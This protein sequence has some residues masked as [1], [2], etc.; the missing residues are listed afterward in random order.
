MKKFILMVLLLLSGCTC[1]PNK[2]YP[3]HIEEDIGITL[4]NAYAVNRLY[5]VYVKFWNRT[6]YD[7]I[8]Q[9]ITLKD[10][11][12]IVECFKRCGYG[13]PIGQRDHHFS[14]NPWPH[15]IRH[16]IV[17]PGTVVNA[18]LTK[19][20]F[21][22]LPSNKNGSVITNVNDY[23]NMRYRWRAAV[24]PSSGKITHRPENGVLHEI[25]GSITAEDRSKTIEWT[26]EY[27]R[28]KLILTLP[29][30]I[31]HKFKDPVYFRED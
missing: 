8:I 20:G 15:D 11:T 27:Y 24:D 14:S 7:Y 28:G 30:G 1:I 16:M 17:Y 18:D 2:I 13:L 12:T 9:E 5:H 19:R 6:E 10:G 26:L 31:V 3:Y 29:G 25:R 23:F 4:H 21:A 22:M